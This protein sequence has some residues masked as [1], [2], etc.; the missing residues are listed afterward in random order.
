MPAP[1]STFRL[2]LARSIYVELNKVDQHGGKTGGR[3][4]PD[5][6]KTQAAGVLRI[7]HFEAALH[8]GP[9]IRLHQQRHIQDN[10]VGRDRVDDHVDSHRAESIQQASRDGGPALFKG[11]FDQLAESRPLLRGHAFVPRQ[12]DLQAGD[13]LLRGYVREDG[14]KIPRDDDH[15]LGAQIPT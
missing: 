7:E 1:T 14:I 12:A 13:G 11:V 15:Q 3:H 4:R 5:A 9:G 6:T 8:C 10:A 2:R